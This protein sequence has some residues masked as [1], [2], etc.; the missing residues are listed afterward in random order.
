MYQEYYSK[1]VKK[2]IPPKIKVEITDENKKFL[3]NFEKSWEE[4]MN[5]NKPLMLQYD[6]IYFLDFNLD[7]FKDCEFII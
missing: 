4:A 7:P 6:E 1:G 2:L 5:K 3:K